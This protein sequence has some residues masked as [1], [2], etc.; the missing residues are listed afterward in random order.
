M[1][2]DGTDPMV[3]YRSSIG[4][5]IDLEARWLGPQMAENCQIFSAVWDS[6]TCA[7]SDTSVAGQPR[8]KAFSIASGISTKLTHLTLGR[9][10]PL[11]TFVMSNR[12]NFGGQTPSTAAPPPCALSA[13]ASMSVSTLSTANSS[14]NQNKVALWKN[15]NY[16]GIINR[17]KQCLKLH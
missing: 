11:R 17:P 1:H 14:Q 9:S 5:T 6:I 16:D 12:T 13:P 8:P 2:L 15:T 10:L 7:I 3:A 4:S